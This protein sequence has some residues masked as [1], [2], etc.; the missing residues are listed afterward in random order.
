MTYS[1]YAEMRL[2]PGRMEFACV[3]D[4]PGG[5]RVVDGRRRDHPAGSLRE[6]C[7]SA[8][9]A[10]PGLIAFTPTGYCAS[11]VWGG[12]IPPDQAKW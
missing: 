1:N 10:D 8:P 3:E 9:V 2:A 11:R 7:R 6:S 12:G 4:T 5:A